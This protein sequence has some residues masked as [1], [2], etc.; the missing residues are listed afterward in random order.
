MGL[1]E[2]RTLDFKNVIMLSVNEGTLPAGRSSNSL[3]LHEVK[4]YFD[5][6]TYQEKDTVYGYHFF[7]LLQRAEQVHLLYNTDSD[8]SL[9]EKSRFL[10]QLDFEISAQH[11]DNIHLHELVLPTMVSSEQQSKEFSIA[12]TDAI[13]ET[14]LNMEY[15]YSQLHTYLNCPLQFY[16]KHVAKI[17]PAE[18]ISESVEQKLIGNAI[19]DLLDEIGQQ[20]IDK[21]TAYPQI[22]SESLRNIDDAVEKAMRKAILGVRDQGSGVRSQGIGLRGQETEK[23]I[24]E[25]DFNNQNSGDCNLKPETCH[26]SPET[27]NLK[28][29]NCHLSPETSKVYIDLTRGKSYL[30]T[31]V[32]KKAVTSYLNKLKEDFEEAE[33]KQYSFKIL[34]TEKKLTAT[35]NVDKQAIKLKGFADRIDLR[36]GLVTLLDYKTG[37]VDDKGLVC[38]NFDDIFTG[39]EHKQLL[40]LLMYAYLFDRGQGSG[41]RD[42]VEGGRWKVEEE[43]SVIRG[44]E[45]ENNPNESKTPTSHL[46]PTTYNYACGII[47]F[48]RLYQKQPHELY[49]TFSSD[50]GSGVRGQVEGG[51]WKVEEEGSGTRGQESEN[52]PNEPKTPTSHLLPATYNHL[53]TPEILQLFEEHLINLL[54]DIINPKLPFCQTDDVS[55]C[56]YCDYSAICK[57]HNTQDI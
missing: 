19:H 39:T 55:H 26:L 29:E 16:L 43:G 12:K 42:Q 57:R 50:Q 27:C 35:V 17:E 32:V 52:N 20:L 24:Q 46:L 10:K 37:Y 34:A 53:I 44:Q 13:V 31:E 8:T 15:T 11:L 30:A 49:P 36:K 18:D 25:T 38:H 33:K 1:L 4:R 14:L 56:R 41:V 47:S 23:R 40:Q 22:I 28:P 21:P 54:R 45:S 3:I 2:T 6:P 48:Q 7:R 51:R 9:A 5:L